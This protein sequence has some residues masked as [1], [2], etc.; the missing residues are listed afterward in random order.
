MAGSSGA[1][2]V[3]GSEG[4][5]NWKTITTDT[6]E[7]VNKTFPQE[8]EPP[9]KPGTETKIIELTQNTK[10]GEFVRVYDNV[11]SGQAGGWVMKA[12]DI[13]GLSPQQ[14]QNKFALPTIPT[15]VTDVIF[16]S[17][18]QLRTGTANRLFGFDG[19]GTQFDLMGQRAGE[20]I[21]GRLLP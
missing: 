4:S 1:G 16:D 9:Y 13:A 10:P 17:G 8:Y 18:T 19:G 7:N 11:N 5:R 12:E 2:V 3:V 20:F 15:H 14:I 21:N 6:A